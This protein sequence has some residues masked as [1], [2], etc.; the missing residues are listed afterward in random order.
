VRLPATVWLGLLGAAFVALLVVVIADSGHVPG[1]AAV[2]RAVQTTFGVVPPSVGDPSE[3]VVFLGF[4]IVTPLFALYRRRWR[5]AVWFIAAVV[6]CIVVAGTIQLAL[7]KTKGGFPSVSVAEAVVTAALATYFSWRRF[8][9]G[10][11]L[12]AALAIADV[13]LI[14]FLVIDRSEHRPSE[15]LG[16]LIFGTGWTIFAVLVAARWQLGAKPKPQ[17]LAGTR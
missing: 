2:A 16:G 13:A 8:A 4:L 14:T 17:V 9:I 15:A 11:Y 10:R 12:I 1:D 3:A 5:T 6:G 7:G